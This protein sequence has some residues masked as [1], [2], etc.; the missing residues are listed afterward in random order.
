MIPWKLL[1]QAKLPGSAED[2]R[3]YQRG[4]EFSIKVGNYELMNSRLYGSEDAMAKLACQK[5]TDQPGTR[6]LVGGLGMGR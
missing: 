1:D 4:N 5:I 3:L 6:V 2:L